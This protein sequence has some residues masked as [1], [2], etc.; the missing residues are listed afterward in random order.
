MFRRIAILI[1]ASG[2][3]AGS[4]NRSPSKSSLVGS[5]PARVFFQVEARSMGT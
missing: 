1:I 2:C 3:L 4:A 5:R